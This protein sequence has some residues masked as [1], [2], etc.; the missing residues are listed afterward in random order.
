[1]LQLHTASI[2]LTAH[3][4]INATHATCKEKAS[5]EVNLKKGPQ[6]E[7]KSES[8]NSPDIKRGMRG[9]GVLQN[10]IGASGRAST[11]TR[12]PSKPGI[13]NDKKRRLSRKLLSNP[14]IYCSPRKRCM[15]CL[16]LGRATRSGCAS[17]K[18]QGVHKTVTEGQKK[19]DGRSRAN[20]RRRTQL[21]L[22]S[23]KKGLSQ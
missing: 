3:K 22:I 23:H 14:G 17:I 21:S 2:A 13:R 4:R 20:S 8:S 11:G 18:K 10:N 5:M 12:V 16:E 6:G 15:T 1:V 7:L 9:E 19:R